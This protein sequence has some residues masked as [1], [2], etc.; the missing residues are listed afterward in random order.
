M[1]PGAGV[2]YR[3]SRYPTNY[4]YTLTLS[5]AEGV[6]P[7]LEAPGE[8]SD[9]RFLGVRVRIVPVYFNP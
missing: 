6:V 4:I 8:N 9:S 7:F 1:A 2:P 5:T 3:P